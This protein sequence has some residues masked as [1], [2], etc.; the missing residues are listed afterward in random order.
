M[1]V[2]MPV[3]PTQKIFRTL[4]E[5]MGHPGRNFSIEMPGSQGPWSSAYLAIARTLLDHEVSFHVLDAIQGAEMTEHIFALTKA[6]P[7]R[8]ENA[9]YIFI[10]G[11][12]SNGRVLSVKTGSAEYPD[13][14]ATIVYILRESTPNTQTGGVGILLEG[15]GIH[16]PRCPELAGLR[17]DEFECIQTL[18]AEYPL[19]VD[20][21]FIG[22]DQ[23]VMAVPRST[24]IRIL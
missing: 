8:L 1:I 23:Q 9:D 15:P 3:Y 17:P 21:F 6:R 10:G 22:P 13:Q 19:G 20:C 24:R 7:E 12:V 4:L 11:P 14:G 16:E 18:N 5:A 2:R